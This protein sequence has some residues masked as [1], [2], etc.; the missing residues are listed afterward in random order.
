MSNIYV[1]LDLMDNDLNTIIKS[2]TPLTEDHNKYFLY[3]ILRGLKYLH[4][5]KIVHRNLKPRSLLVN[6]NCDLKITGFEMAK[7]LTKKKVASCLSG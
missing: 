4:S 1:V 3:Q 7:P 6:L 2:D 5:A